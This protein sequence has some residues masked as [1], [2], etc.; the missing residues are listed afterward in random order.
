MYALMQRIN[1]GGPRSARVHLRY[2]QRR[3]PL[4]VQR[5]DADAK[6]GEE[7]LTSCAE[8]TESRPGAASETLM[9]RS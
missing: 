8:G 6:P 1:H 7:A 2:G 4:V 5:L 9:N 3:A